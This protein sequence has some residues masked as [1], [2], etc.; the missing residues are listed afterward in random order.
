[1]VEKLYIKYNIPYTVLR[2]NL[3]FHHKIIKKKDEVKHWVCLTHTYFQ[4]DITT[5]NA[6]DLP[7]VTFIICLYAT[8]PYIS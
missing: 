6:H 1:M 7:H 2:L 8:I 5:D 3:K 4:I